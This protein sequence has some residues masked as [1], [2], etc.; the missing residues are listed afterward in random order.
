[1]LLHAYINIKHV[2]SSKLPAVR[3]AVAQY[4]EQQP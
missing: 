4:A 1:M 2:I 3:E